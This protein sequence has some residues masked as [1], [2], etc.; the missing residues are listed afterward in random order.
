MR[1]LPPAATP[2]ELRDLAA[3]L[4]PPTAALAEFCKALALYL[5]V[6]AVFLAATG[7]TALY[8][9]L[10]TLKAEA[11]TRRQVVLPAYTCPALV[12]VVEAA[13]LTPRLVDIVPETLTFGRDE[14]AATLGDATLAVVLVH[15]FGIPHAVE[16]V[17]ALAHQAGARLIEDAAQSLGA[18]IGPRRA[19]TLG[20]SGLF[21]LGPG[22]ALSTG[23][24]GIV[25]TQDA[26]LAERLRIA[27]QRLPEAGTAA[28]VAAAARLTL[29]SAAFHPRGWYWAAKAGAQRLGEN[30]ATWGFGLRPLTAGQAVVGLTLLARLDAINRAR[31]LRAELYRAALTAMP[32]VC[33]PAPGPTDPLSQ[34]A[35][36]VR[37]P[38]LLASETQRDRLHRALWAAGIGAGRMYQK[39]LAEFFPVY[40]ETAYPGAEAVAR[41]LLTL[42]THHYVTGPDIE[43]TLAI[44]AGG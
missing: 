5:G 42:P 13:G 15:P 20:D 7:R 38:L 30:E 41:R 39:T 4:T 25:C 34:G 11:P 3:A 33:V 2:I 43:R 23:G 40:A 44:L 22:K 35:I 18:K 9:L 12:K 27:W 31:R 26:A 21:S 37:L 24:G 10:E 29:M 36:Y 8:L 16:W 28:S 1:H 32:G 6:R 19:G 17:K 14:L